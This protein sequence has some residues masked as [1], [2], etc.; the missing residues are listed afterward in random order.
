MTFDRENY[1]LH[2]HDIVGKDDMEYVYVYCE[3]ETIPLEW[4]SSI[5][6]IPDKEK[7]EGNMIFINDGSKHFKH[8]LYTND[9]WYV[10]VM[11]NE[12]YKFTERK[13]K[14]RD[15]KLEDLLDLRLRI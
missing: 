3:H 6:S 11:T 15:I 13:A 9:V 1:I 8:M 4:Y 12:L 10:A 5:G 14:L 2:T 7:F